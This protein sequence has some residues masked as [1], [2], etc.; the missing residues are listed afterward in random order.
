MYMMV[1]NIHNTYHTL[2]TLH[3]EPHRIDILRDKGMATLDEFI[4]EMGAYAD[5]IVT[6]I[7]FG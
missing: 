6:E 5:E 4:A 1:R 3:I 7:A 2:Y